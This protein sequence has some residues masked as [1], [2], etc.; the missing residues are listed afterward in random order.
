MYG[1]YGSQR[2]IG[3][4]IGQAGEQVGETASQ[5]AERARET[6][7]RVPQQFGEFG[8]Q[9]G[10]TAQRVL[11]ENPLAVAGVALAVGAFW[12]TSEGRSDAREQAFGDAA[13]GA[14]LGATSISEAVASG[15]TALAQLAATPG[16][17]SVFS[18]PARPLLPLGTSTCVVSPVTTTREPKP[19]RVRNI[20]I[21]SGVAFCA[22]SRMMKLPLSVRPR[23]NASGATSTI[24][25]SNS[26]CTASGSSMS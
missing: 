5:V 19:I 21:C 12:K 13:F 17:S 9:V 20:F 24:W 8:D 25:R 26:R 6:A 3:D 22:S 10:D 23:M 16:L 1:D 14:Q 11:E 2:G 18:S 7:E 15:Q 4:K